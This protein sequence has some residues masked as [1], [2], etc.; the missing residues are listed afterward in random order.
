MD[1]VTAT[2]EGGQPV[3]VRDVH[4][5][6]AGADRGVTG[7]APIQGGI[8][9]QA[10]TISTEDQGRTLRVRVRD[11]VEFFAQK[12]GTEE[13]ELLH[14][15]DERDMTERQAS[16]ASQYVD[17]VTPDG[18][19]PVPHEG[20]RKTAGIDRSRFATMA[21]HERVGA[22]TDE[23]KRL[24][25]SLARTKA[26]LAEEQKAMDGEIAQ[27]KADAEAAK[28]PAPKSADAFA[29]QTPNQGGTVQA[30]V[31]ANR[32]TTRDAQ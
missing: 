19:K 20:Q 26:A 29:Q 14:G 5:P 27:R 15:G 23:V 11:G 24:E 22:L 9:P 30:P 13:M 28:S 6:I 17:E 12:I 1:S 10:Q 8:Q 25:D 31:P 3:E 32:V 16:A 4:T 18:L 2:N 7:A 21:R